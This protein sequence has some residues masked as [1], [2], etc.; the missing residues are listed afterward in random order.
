MY[1]LPIRTPILHAGDDVAAI[2]SHSFSFRTGDILC[3]SSKAVATAEGVRIDLRSLT[4]TPDARSSAASMGLSSAFVQAVIDEAARLR[5]RIVGHC[6]GA[7]LTEVRPIGSD[8]EMLVPNAGLD[9]SNVSEGSAIGWSH[10]PVASARALSRRLGV[11]VILTDSC[12]VMRRRGVTAFALCCCGIDPLR[13]EIG[14]DDLFGK[15]LRITVE[16]VADQLAC[17]ANAVMGNAA[18]C[19]P[20]AVI[21]GHG[22]PR[23]DFCDWVPCMGRKEDLFSC[24][25]H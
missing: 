9:Q 25:L 24:L 20:A 12:C 19:T 8:G 14:R 4:I 3:V 5:G 10:D 15:P 17:A 2:L 13:S 7:L 16:A 22:I 21:R 23:S 1:I 6:P 18:Q 11:P